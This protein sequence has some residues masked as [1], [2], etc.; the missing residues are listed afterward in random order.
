MNSESNIRT[1]RREE[2]EMAR[3]EKISS[4]RERHDERV[5]LEAEENKRLAQENEE[6][7]ARLL[8]NNVAEVKKLEEK[9]DRQIAE[10][11]EQLDALIPKIED[12]DMT[13]SEYQ[14]LE[15]KILEIDD[16]LRELVRA[17]NK[18]KPI[19]LADMKTNANLWKA[20][21]QNIIRS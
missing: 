4:I 13:S 17:K 6:A 12:V 20:L 21:D 10:F 8:E 19:K 7:E 2:L 3:K 1:E 15:S 16:N 18:P 9:R 11:E 14:I 5:R